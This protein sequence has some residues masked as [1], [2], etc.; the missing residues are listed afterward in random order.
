V[1]APDD[2]V[3]RRQPRSFEEQMQTC[4]VE[5]R[6]DMCDADPRPRPGARAQPTDGALVQFTGGNRTSC[7]PAY[8]RS[9]HASRAEF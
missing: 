4:E 6:G 3:R 1:V 9:V 7:E 8:D 2:R 5:P